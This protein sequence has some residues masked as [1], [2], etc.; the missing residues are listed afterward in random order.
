MTS[1][2]R[3]TWTPLG[4]PHAGDLDHGEAGPVVPITLGPG[5][6]LGLDDPVWGR[7][8]I[9]ALAVGVSVLESERGLPAPTPPP[10]LVAEERDV[11][12]DLLHRLIHAERPSELWPAIRDARLALEH[13][14]GQ[15]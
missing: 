6:V 8:L 9:A 10:D 2:R 15:P 14:A 4:R 3:T 5:E 13:W 11:Y 12:R 7:D 1:I